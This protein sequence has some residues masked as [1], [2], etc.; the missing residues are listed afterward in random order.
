MPPMPPVRSAGPQRSRLASGLAGAALVIAVLTV[1][2]RVAGFGRQL[3]FNGTVGQTGLGDAYTT[4][5]YV[6]NIV[7]DI[8]A[9]GALASLV[10]PLLAG[11]I[12]RGRAEETRRTASA[13][14]TWTVVVLVPVTVAGLLVARPLMELLLRDKADVPGMLD[15]ATAFLIAFLPQVPLYGLAVV[16]A[17]ILQAH[18]RFTAAAVAPLVSSV[19]VA[20]AYL[21]FAAGFD[22]DKNDPESIPRGSELVLGLGTTAGVLALALCTLL[23][24]RGTDVRLRPTL[25]FPDGV[26]R[27]ARLLALAGVATLVAQQLATVTVLMLVNAHGPEGGAVAYQNA[28][29][30]Y[31]LPYAILA[32]PIATSAF[33]RL[34]AAAHDGDHPGFAGTAAATTRVVLLVSFAGAALLAAT[35]YPVGAFFA[36]L[37]GGGTDPA[38]MARALI[39]FA[40][41][42][43]GYGLVAHLGRALYARGHGRASAGAVVLGWLAVIVTDVLLVPAVDPD[44]AVAALGLGNTVG[45]TLAGALLL[46]ATAQ[47]AG[48]PALRGVARSAAAG[49]VAA[50]AGGTAGAALAHAL[51]TGGT[52]HSLITGAAAAV[53]GA[54]VFAAVAYPTAGPDTRALAARLRGRGRKTPDTARHD[55][56]DDGPGNRPDGTGA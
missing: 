47:V 6:P 27:R 42:L 53:A 4:A 50:G 44:W 14:L 23:P 22:G 39:A 19:V 31:V 43:A 34:S 11:P 9:G 7:F 40:P 17:G 37:S 16:S 13:L 5:N 12:A 1:L 36:A 32:V 46:A 21:L 29:M 55:D 48:R 30:V 3:V 38:V 33:P 24:L 10:V 28:W 49:A 8:V 15:L 2:A 18:N 35:A 20:G 52:A 56:T 54:A 25:R 26:A 45:M 41:G 51:G